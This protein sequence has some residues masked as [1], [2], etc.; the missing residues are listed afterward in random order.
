M[1]DDENARLDKLAKTIHRIASDENRATRGDGLHIVESQ[2]T[3]R[4]RASG[5]PAVWP[6]AS[7]LDKFAR[8]Y[9]SRLWPALVLMA[10]PFA[11]MALAVIYW[12]GQ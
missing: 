1:T 5:V 12:S 9:N 11:L 2:R 8:W 7:R 10:L 3:E 6:V 4:H